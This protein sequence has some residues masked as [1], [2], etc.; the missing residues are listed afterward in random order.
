MDENDAGQQQRDTFD[1][2][3]IYAA[4]TPPR[5]IGPPPE[6]RSN[7]GLVAGL[8][9]LCV[10]VLGLF[11]WFVVGSLGEEEE[12]VDYESVQADPVA[13]FHERTA[14]LFEDDVPPDQR[15]AVGQAVCEFTDRSTDP[16]TVEQ[17][18]TAT[19]PEADF[20]LLFDASANAWCPE[21]AGLLARR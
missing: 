9:V 4:P 3:S 15:E 21:H 7:K 13:R 1:P 16:R 11:A 20:R 6:P 14:D 8:A 5:V 12:L 19:Y 17:Y 2:A 10:V 18:F